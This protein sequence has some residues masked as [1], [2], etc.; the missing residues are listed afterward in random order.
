MKRFLKKRI[1]TLCSNV[2][3]MSKML[4]IILMVFAT[5]TS[6]LYAA[7]EASIIQ[8]KEIKGTVT[9]PDN[10]PLPG[11]NILVIGTTTGAETD[12]DGNYTIKANKGDVLQFSFVG[13]ETKLVTVGDNTTINVA[14]VEDANALEEVVVV[15]YG[16]QTKAKVTGAIST[17]SSKDMVTIPTTNAIEAL[18]G[19]TSGLTLI[20]SGSPGST[21]TIRIRGVGTYGNNK[22]IFVVDGIVVDDINGLS[23]NDIES[24]SV[25]K[26]ASTAAVYGSNGANGVIVIKTKTGKKGSTSFNFDTYYSVKFKP[27]TLDLLNSEQYV[28]FVSDMVQ[29][30]GNALPP[31]FA[32]T[33]FISN[34]V[35]YQDAIFQDAVSQ[36]YILSASGGNE[37]SRFRFSGNY[38]TQEGT[39]INT[40]LDKYSFRLN[41]DFSRGRFTFGETLSLTYSEQDPLI[42]A[43]SVS[44][45]ENAFKIAPYLPIFN[46]N[47]IGGYSE[48][49]ATL[50]INNTRNPL[51]TLNRETQLNKTI[52]MLGNVFLKAKLFEGL[53]YKSS[54]GMN[55][56]DNKFKKVELPYGS[57]A[58]LQTDTRFSYF[59][60]RNKTI[61]FQNSL[62]FTKTLNDKHTFKILALAEQRKQRITT[63]GGQG[64]TALGVNDISGIAA[65]AGTVDYN[66]IG[67]LGRLNYDF[68]GKYIFAASVR[69]DASSRFGS[70]NRWGTF[71]SFAL[72]W[73]ISKEDFFNADGAM[74]YLKLRASYGTAGNDASA[75]NY[76]YESSLL[77]N[78]F[79]TA[80]VE[81]IAI[82]RL[83]NPDLK[84]EETEMTN[85]GLDFGFLNNALT[86]SAEYYDNTSS[87]LIVLVNPAASVGVPN[88]TPRNF[89][90]VTTNGLEFNLGYKH[91]GEEF[92]W[93]AN[94][95]L[96][97]TKNEVTK[98]Y[99]DAIFVGAKPNVLQN[100]NISR[101]AEGEAIY[102]FYG[103]QTDGI[104]QTQAEVDASA[105][106]GT[107]AA[108]G[109]FRFRDINGRDANGNLTG[110][111]DGKIDDDDRTVIGNPFPKVNYGLSF[112]AN[113][114]NFDINVFFTGV[115]GNDIF[116]ASRYYLDGSSQV[117][118]ASTAV[119]DRWTPTNP[120]NTQPRAIQGDPNGNTRV[121]DR[122]VE[123]GS[124][125]R[126]KN[127]SVGYNIPSETLSSFAGGSIS[128]FR[129]YL[130]SQNLF[131]ITNYSGYDPEIGPSLGIAATNGNTNS[132]IGIDRG[133]YPQ[134]KS[135]LFGIQIQ[136]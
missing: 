122:Y 22:P 44:P 11:V 121:S 35:D 91:E 6:Q 131:T 33:A 80:G 110:L 95:N 135:L 9:G 100:G 65:T 53:E 47:N 46:P 8:Q 111:P 113:Y 52:N 34:N 31:R 87:D 27:K 28:S 85:I 75:G 18:Q 132:E 94:F 116:N 134:S 40:S 23:A 4:S 99:E 93:S 21:P 106:A 128:K 41:S 118:N 56:F 7:S 68:E 66:K 61:T 62:L 74:N 36:N 92:K 16:S 96:S 13:M 30:A 98:L 123:D 76:A 79:Y 50:D 108:P 19:K 88:A 127:I 54:I 43:F 105:Q 114:K 39:M 117:N 89:G 57:G 49:D 5:F 115:A 97:T 55:F 25:L 32:D 104:F 120:S 1:D 69:R 37:N 107:G 78:Y 63:L 125:L 70:N 72:G 51:R 10:S 124:Y 73:V 77:A 2:Q 20:N 60:V 119:L 59:D 12:F 86:F 42:L 101:L 133:Q 3:G 129:F 90:G 81:G 26:D 130:S 102:H 17:V 58:T 45:L 67:Y 71:S 29:N 136:F 84:W 83:S 24:A 64:T 48:L 38:Q 103:W 82:S 14:L 15:G 109:D 126:L 112:D